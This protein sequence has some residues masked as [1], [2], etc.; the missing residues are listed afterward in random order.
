MDFAIAILAV[1]EC[2]LAPITVGWIAYA[3]D[4]QVTVNMLARGGCRTRGIHPLLITNKLLVLP[5]TE[6]RNI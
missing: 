6:R 4:T 5:E 2:I 1:A 3:P